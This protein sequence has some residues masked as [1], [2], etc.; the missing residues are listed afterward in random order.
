MIILILC[1]NWLT[2]GAQYPNCVLFMFLSPLMAFKEGA[3]ATGV[4]KTQ[5]QLTYDHTSYSDEILI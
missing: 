4:G 5:N 1:I 3:T 2:G